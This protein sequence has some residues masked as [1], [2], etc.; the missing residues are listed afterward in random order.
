MTLIVVT[1]FVFVLAWSGIYTA[2]R[3]VEEPLRLLSL[4]FYFIAGWYVFP[5]A[6]RIHRILY[7]P[8][9]KE[10]DDG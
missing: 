2:F 10:E 3:D 7:G 4:P 6:R 1:V 5:V 8:P 9:R